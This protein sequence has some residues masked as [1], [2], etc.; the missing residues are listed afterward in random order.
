MTR[1]QRIET[2]KLIRETAQRTHETLELMRKIAQRTCERCKYTYEVP[3][4]VFVDECNKELDALSSR[5]VT[6]L[7]DKP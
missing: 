5:A 4:S 1:Q 2:L 7:D 6:S 3:I